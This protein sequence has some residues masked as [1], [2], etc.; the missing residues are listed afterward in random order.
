MVMGMMVDQSLERLMIFRLR[1]NGWEL[2]DG[3]ETTRLNWILSHYTEQTIKP[4]F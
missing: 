4:R 2:E 3:G 1:L